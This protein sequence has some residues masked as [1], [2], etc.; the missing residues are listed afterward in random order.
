MK[1]VGLKGKR[2]YIM[3]EKEH[4]EL[5]DMTCEMDADAM[6]IIHDI[7]WIDSTNYFTNQFTGSYIEFIRKCADHIA[8]CSREIQKK[9]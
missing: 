1:K 8:A 9:L 5:L 7:F 3:T 2:I 4:D 6:M